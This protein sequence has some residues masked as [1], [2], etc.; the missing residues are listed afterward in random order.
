MSGDIITAECKQ[1]TATKFKN[2][3]R[4]ESYITSIDM[5]YDADDTTFTRSI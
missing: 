1:T 5:D 3:E 4:F 2:T